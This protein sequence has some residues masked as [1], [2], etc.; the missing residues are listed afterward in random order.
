MSFLRNA[1]CA[2]GWASELALRFGTDGVCVHNRHGNGFIPSSACV[3]SD[4][5]I[6]RH[7]V[8]WI[9]MG[10]AS[11]FW[12]HKPVLLAGDAAAVRARRILDKLIESERADKPAAQTSEAP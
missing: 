3:R 9:W 8:L 10:A 1:W 4:P 2:A 6:E 7:S 12:R 5:V 11:A